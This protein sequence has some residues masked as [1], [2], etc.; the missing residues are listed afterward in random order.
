MPSA[1]DIA[2]A[3][4]RGGT[5]S[6]IEVP[7]VH[8]RHLADLFRLRGCKVGAEV[9]VEKGAYAE[10]ILS[11]N[12]GLHLY[13]IDAWLA[14]EG[15]RNHVKQ[16]QV[17]GLFVSAQRR[18]A[19]HRVTF[20]KSMSVEASSQFGDASLDFVFIDANHDEPHVYADLVAWAPKVR[21]GGIV[22]GHDYCEGWQK[23]CGT[24]GVI[25]AVHRFVRERGI[26]TWFVLGDN[27][28]VRDTGR[29]EPRSFMWV[30]Q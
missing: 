8:R 21:P 2:Q 15:Y 23:S 7:G 3:I 18:L 12:P 30:V 29:Q 16:E 22:S 28:M 24:V 4:A 1:V 17:D 27:A 14:Y 6:P 20:I 5:N 9:G 19:G 10:Q 25:P 26:Q 13:C 11:R